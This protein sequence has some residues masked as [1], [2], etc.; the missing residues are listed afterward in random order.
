M[1]ST[2][3]ESVPTKVKDEHLE[4]GKDIVTVKL[5]LQKNWKEQNNRV[6]IPVWLPC[7]HLDAM[8]PTSQ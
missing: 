6:Y 8:Q 5:L 2:V 1:H 7:I 4:N 3:L